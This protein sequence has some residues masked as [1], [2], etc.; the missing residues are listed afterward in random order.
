ME[1]TTSTKEIIPKERLEQVYSNGGEFK[2]VI[3]SCDCTPS[4]QSVKIELLQKEEVLSERMIE[5]VYQAS[6]PLYNSNEHGKVANHKWFVLKEEYRNQKISSKI[7]V[8]EL[9]TYRECGIKQVHLDAAY[10]GI[11]VWSKSGFKFVT[12][13]DENKIRHELFLFFLEEKDMSVE[14]ARKLSKTDFKNLTKET[15]STNRGSFYDRFVYG[16]VWQAFKM[17]K[18]V[19]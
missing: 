9:D 5:R 15:L 4:E 10:E 2:G 13:S 11:I 7:Q 19:V 18:D 3:I 14:R 6:K 16:N 12:Q 1:I 17:Y 8:N